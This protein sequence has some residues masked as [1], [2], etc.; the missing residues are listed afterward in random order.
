[1]AYYLCKRGWCGW[2]AIIVVIVIIEMLSRR[3]VFECLLLKRKRKNVLNKF[4]S[5]LKEEPDL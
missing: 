2:H 4:N 1:M 5:D 3:K